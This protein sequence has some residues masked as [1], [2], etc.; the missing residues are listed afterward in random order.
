LALRALSAGLAGELAD[1]YVTR[2]ETPKGVGSRRQ[3]HALLSE[4]TLAGA[5]VQMEDSFGEILDEGVA[6][7]KKLGG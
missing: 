2:G 5:S 6:R 1:R 4:V 7:L 3:R